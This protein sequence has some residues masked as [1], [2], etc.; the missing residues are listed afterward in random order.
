MESAGA[1][2]VGVC[3]SHLAG[4]GCF[5]LGQPVVT[6]VRGNAGPGSDVVEAAA[7]IFAEYGGFIRA[8]IGF[9]THHKSEEEDLFQAFFLALIRRPMPA[10]V[11]NIKSYL[12]Q[13]ITNHV[14]DFVRRRARYCAAVKKYAKEIRIPINNCP[15]ENVLIED[16]EEKNAIIVSFARHL[17]QRQ[18]QAFLLRYRD[19]FSIRE[20]A[21]KM[22]VKG[23]TVSRYLSDSIR[24]LRKVLAT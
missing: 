14:R 18:A 24:T 17:Q 19:H 11:Q 9:Q 8:V 16:T 23:R 2:R 15:A 6:E 20:I 5:W 21:V 12:Y 4:G 3:A 1:I 10:D 13:A 7:G 22:G